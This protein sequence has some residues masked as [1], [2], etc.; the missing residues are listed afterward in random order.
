M[1]KISYLTAS[2][3][4]L[5]SVLSSFRIG[6]HSY[7]NINVRHKNEMDFLHSIDSYLTTISDPKEPAFNKTRKYIEQKL[8]A[9]QKASLAKAKQKEK[10]EKLLQLFA[11]SSKHSDQF[12]DPRMLEDQQVRRLLQGNKRSFGSFESTLALPEI[13]F[14]YSTKNLLSTRDAEKK[15]NKILYN[16]TYRHSVFCKKN[17]ILKNINIIS[18]TSGMQKNMEK[19]LDEGGEIDQHL[20]ER[21]R[22]ESLEYGQIKH[23]IARS[24]VVRAKIF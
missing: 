4:K 12:I 24:L 16:N 19:P 6:S 18:P 22:K 1:E 11:H 8:K 14:G 15:L 3:K 5:D 17:R 20:R 2:A 10:E 9:Q 21:I 7:Q 13:K 23:K